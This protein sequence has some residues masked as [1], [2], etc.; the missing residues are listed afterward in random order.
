MG[1]IAADAGADRQLAT[2]WSSTTRCTTRCRRRPSWP[3]PAAPA[4]SSSRTT[5]CARWSAGCEHYRNTHRRVWYAA[6]GLYSMYADFFP[7]AELDAL[8]ARHDNLWLYVDDAHAFS[9]T[10]RHGRGYALEHLSPATLARTVVAVSLNKS[11]AA[12]GGAITF[13]DEESAPL[14]RHRRRAADLL[15]AGAAADAR[16]RSW[17]PPGCTA[18]PEIAARQELLLRRIRL[19]NRLAADARL[20]ARVGVRGA[21]PLR[22]RR[23]RLGRLPADRADCATSGF[24][25][26][27]ATF[28]AVPAKRCGRPAHPHRPPHRGRRRR[29]RR[30]TG[31][32]PAPPR[33]PTRERRSRTSAAPSPGSCAAGRGILPTPRRG[34]PD[35]P[36]AGAGTAP[37]RTSTRWSGTPSWARAAPSTSP[38]CAPWRPSSATGGAGGAGQTED[39]WDFTYL[40]VRDADGTPVAATFFTTAL[41]KDDMLSPADVSR[42]VERRRKEAADPWFLTSPMIGMGSLLT[43][44][45]HL[46]LDRSARL[47]H[48]AADD[49]AGGAGGGGRGRCR[50]GG[51]AR[52]ARRRRRPARLPAGRGAAPAAGDRLLGPA[53]RLRRRRGVPRRAPR[54]PRY[55][56]RT[57]VLP[58][59]PAFRWRCSRAGRP[60]AAAYARGA[61]RRPLPA[62][63]ERA[64][65]RA[66]LN[67]FPL[68]RRLLD[69][70]LEQPGMGDHRCCAWPSAR[71]TIPWRSPSRT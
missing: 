60:A 46:Y 45:D 70:V 34:V 65:P 22:R 35:G 55:H 18:P 17:P 42:E 66:D 48:R 33:S 11:F 21:D 49:P 24:F 28:P 7:A 1:H 3:R 6:D 9:W 25:V 63:P 30:G 47:A 58:W 29:R 59:E 15:R 67:V 10:G 14:R 12:A 69:A 64:R 37:S 44:G 13:P 71:T 2:C 36:A 5:T 54:K 16:A 19:F 41:W 4:S 39:A 53:D 27:T 61:P 51:A 57:Q 23:R 52:P 31:R 43:E 26:N 50:R 38:R 32:E 40:V 62:L 56:Q 8:A 20:P 68:P